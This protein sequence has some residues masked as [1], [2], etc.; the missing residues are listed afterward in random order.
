MGWVDVNEAA[1]LAG[2]ASFSLGKG[3]YSPAVQSPGKMEKGWMFS[4]DM[5]N[6]WQLKHKLTKHSPKPSSYCLRQT[7]KVMKNKLFRCHNS[8]FFFSRW[9]LY[10]NVCWKYIHQCFNS[11]KW[12]RHFS[13]VSFSKYIWT[14]LLELPLMYLLTVFSDSKPSSIKRADW[15]FGDNLLLR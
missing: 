9:I 5:P 12:T 8:K 10:Q 2:S 7:F 3:T 6:F 1:C 13:D 4:K 14:P 11:S 15:V